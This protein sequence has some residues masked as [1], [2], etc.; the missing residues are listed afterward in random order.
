MRVHKRLKLGLDELELSPEIR[1]LAEKAFAEADLNPEGSIDSA[2]RALLQL[3]KQTLGRELNSRTPDY[4]K[5]AVRE[6]GAIWKSRLTEV[7]ANT[8]RILRNE[9]ARREGRPTTSAARACAFI[10][11]AV[12]RA[13]NPT[14]KRAGSE[15]GG[16]S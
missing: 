8:I 13:T 3:L 7:E 9:S 16:I 12:L 15:P 2:D 11:I 10:L 14:R 1:R 6:V 5:N 4:V